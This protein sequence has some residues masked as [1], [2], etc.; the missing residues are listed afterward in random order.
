[1]KK[2]FGEDFFSYF[3]WTILGC[4]YTSRIIF[5]NRCNFKNKN[6]MI[7]V[8]PFFAG[9]VDTGEQFLVMSLTPA[10]N[11]RMLGYF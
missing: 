9:L 4:V 2:N 10:I 5:S 6:I 8:P 1:M 3:V 11:S 7:M